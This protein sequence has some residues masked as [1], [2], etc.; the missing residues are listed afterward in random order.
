MPKKSIRQ[1]LLLPYCALV[2]LVALIL[3]FL[4]YQVVVDS[5]A[6]QQHETLSLHSHTAA[7]HVSRLLQHRKT[8][9]RDIAHS[10]ATE[11]YAE[12]YA[13]YS[14]SR[15]FLDNQTT[16][17]T[18]S[19]INE[20]GVEEERTV[21]GQIEETYRDLAQHPL[22]SPAAAQPNTTVVSD[23]VLD[24]NGQPAIDFMYHHRNFFDEFGGIIFGTASL[25]ALTEPA[26]TARVGELG[27][28]SVVGADGQVLSY[29]DKNRLL[30][31][32][33]ATDDRSR[34]LLRAALSGHEVF[35]RARILGVDGY[36]ASAPIAG[37]DWT[38]IATLPVD[39]FLEAPTALR[40]KILIVTMLTILLLFA[41]AW[42]LSRYI[43]KPLASLLEATQAVTRGDFSRHTAIRSG[44]EFQ[45]LS[46]AFNH[47]TQE[48]HL[49]EERLRRARDEA[50]A[51]RSA[52]EQAAR[53]KADFLATMSHEIRTPMNGVIGMADYLVRTEL[54]VEQRECAEMIK[55]S[56]AQLLRVV[57]DVL[58]YS[59]MENGKVALEPNS[60][61]LR[62]FVEQTTELAAE[63]AVNKGV[64]IVPVVSPRMPYEVIAD[65]GRL[66]QVLGNL[67]S[68]AVKFTDSGEISVHGALF[69]RGTETNLRCE[70]HDTGL[71]IADDD[72]VS[73]FESFAQADSSTTRRYE[74]TGLGLAICRQLIELMGGTIGV[75]S[76]L[77]Q[78][79]RFWF[80]IPVERGHPTTAAGDTR[81]RGFRA[82]LVEDNATARGT[83]ARQLRA[84]GLHVTAVE[85]HRR[86]FERL[87]A[88]D[89]DL[90]VIDRTLRGFDGLTLA[91]RV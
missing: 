12:N 34:G 37:T 36:V 44:D 29:P 13:F 52:A 50:E 86:A 46:D 91:K 81:L 9:L 6:E 22:F 28:I 24:A 38:V 10:D 18:L 66:R 5:L 70:V 83:L 47:M 33:S 75:E 15:L 78:G 56:G 68:N 7:A 85:D 77:G 74:G 73:I 79:S 32:A 59:K 27:F 3:G 43:T 8:L 40:N 55:L 25:E 63:D 42:W 80:E 17:P 19:F 58:D 23:I 88:E 65:E 76:E 62:N 14:L 90:A 1:K 31:T 60:F 4:C 89:F 45:I 53:V 39:E 30:Q 82:L 11:R 54:D 16:F 67:V 35:G 51:A 41:V 21:N 26:A 87:G 61:D 69:E 64:E 48:R 84:L 20:S 57:N 2:L 71:G 72:L 49:A